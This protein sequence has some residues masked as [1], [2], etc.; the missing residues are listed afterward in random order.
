[1]ERLNNF[2]AGDSFRLFLWKDIITQIQFKTFWG[3]GINSYKTIN[4]IY[5]SNEITTARSLNLESA[6]QQYIP[7]TVH[8]HSDYLQTILEIGFFGTCV[9]VF[10]LFFALARAFMLNVKTKNKYITIALIVV[11]FYS[12]VD[13]PFR[14]IAVSSLF[15]FLLSSRITSLNRRNALTM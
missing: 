3:Y 11:I 15:V 1:M 4:G 7:V 13:F 8:A 6:H 2:I 5:Q 12:I 10:P 14:N 9:L